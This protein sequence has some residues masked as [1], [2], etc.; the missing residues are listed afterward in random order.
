MTDFTKEAGAET[1]E[2]AFAA[3][4]EQFLGEEGE[5][6][7]KVQ[8][9]RAE[10]VEDW[11]VPW[12][13]EPTDD[14]RWAIVPPGETLAGG[15]EVAAYCDDPREAELYTVLVPVSRREPRFTLGAEQTSEYGYPIYEK[16]EVVGHV[17]EHDEELVM[18]MNMATALVSSPKALS[19]ILERAGGTKLE[20][21]VE[22]SFAEALQLEKQK[23]ERE[24]EE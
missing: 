21:A 14:G 11:L 5:R 8:A 15:A 17:R 6:E 22:Y 20:Q 19:L 16:G 13:I 3:D 10:K 1:P 18:R 12:D 7:A 2:N 4:F 23:R 24:E 9:L